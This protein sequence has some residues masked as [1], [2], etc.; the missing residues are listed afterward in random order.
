MLAR[1]ALSWLL[2]HG[3]PSSLRLRSSPYSGL[4]GGFVSSSS[5]FQGAAGANSARNGTKVS[6]VSKVSKVFKEAALF[7]I[8]VF[9]S[10][11]KTN[12]CKLGV[13]E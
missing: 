3:T 7:D 2:R 5:P 8:F 13:F 10:S 12:Y 4:E 1:A 9:P 6:K 11:G